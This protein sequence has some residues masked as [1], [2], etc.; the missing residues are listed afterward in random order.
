MEPIV[1]NEHW[2]KSNFEIFF[3]SWRWTKIEHPD[4]IR[5]QMFTSFISESRPF[6]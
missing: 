6:Y 2:N 3:S 5:Y 1:F 4:Y